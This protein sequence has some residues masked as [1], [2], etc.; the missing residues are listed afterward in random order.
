MNQLSLLYKK[1]ENFV[2]GKKEK[3]SGFK[4]R[5]SGLP[6]CALGIEGK[7]LKPVNSPK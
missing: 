2:K 3:V 4:S 1:T 5:V 6:K 7:N